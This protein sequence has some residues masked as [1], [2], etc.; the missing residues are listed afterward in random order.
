MVRTLYFSATGA[1]AGW[2]LGVWL[3]GGDFNGWMSAT[4]VAL[5][6]AGVAVFALLAD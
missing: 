3:A 2:P 1:V 5:Y 4:G 6:F